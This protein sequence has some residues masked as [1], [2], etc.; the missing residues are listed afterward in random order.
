MFSW[1]VQSANGDRQQS[2]CKRWL[3]F[4]SPRR[5]N[6][7]STHSCTT[8]ETWELFWRGFLPRVGTKGLRPPSSDPADNLMRLRKLC[9]ETSKTDWPEIRGRTISVSGDSLR[10]GLRKWVFPHSQLNPHKLPHS[11]LNAAL[12]LSNNR[13]HCILRP[14]QSRTFTVQQGLATT[15]TTIVTTK[16]SS[17]STPSLANL[18]RFNPM[19]LFNRRE[20]DALCPPLLTLPQ[21]H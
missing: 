18:E 2:W 4:A 7:A 14:L 1:L 5:E 21:S 17:R 13:P 10:M 8:R 15:V 6:C 3:R 20:V 16:V 12:I 9:V 11:A 19:W